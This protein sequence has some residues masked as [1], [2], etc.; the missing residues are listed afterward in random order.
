M[1]ISEIRPKK[2]SI[3]KFLDSGSKVK[4][5]ISTTKLP[6]KKTEMWYCTDQHL[7]PNS[8]FSSLPIASF[9]NWDQPKIWPNGIFTNPDVPEKQGISLPK[10]YGNWGGGLR[11][12]A[13]IWPDKWL[14]HLKSNF[15]NTTF[16]CGI[17]SQQFGKGLVMTRSMRAGGGANTLNHHIKNHHCSLMFKQFWIF[18]SEKRCTSRDLAW[19]LILF[20]GESL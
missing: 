13:I 6:D 14:P 17:R 18:C 19:C 16:Q 5:T 8:S 12:V 7:G 1:K 9:K 10:S 11:E 3:Y 4:S 2:I 20:F 15:R